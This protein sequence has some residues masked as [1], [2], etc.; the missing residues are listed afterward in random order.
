M[1]R[2]RK[3]GMMHVNEPHR[4][5]EWVDRVFPSASA[6]IFDGYDTLP[7]IYYSVFI[8]VWGSFTAVGKNNVN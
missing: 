7:D 3:R 1:G 8:T 4:T 5:I 6:V 2:L